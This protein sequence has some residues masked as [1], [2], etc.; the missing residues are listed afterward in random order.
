M[1]AGAWHDT[2]TTG[3]YIL[4][5]SLYRVLVGS[6][7]TVVICDKLWIFVFYL[8][9]GALSL[10]RFQRLDRVFQVARGL[11]SQYS[12]VCLFVDKRAHVVLDEKVFQ[13]K[14]PHV[15]FKIC[16]AKFLV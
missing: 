15:C 14:R 7:V 1:N 10:E 13:Q 8:V 9:S 16:N 6:K 3:K 5:Y 11:E 2:A 4:V 12:Q